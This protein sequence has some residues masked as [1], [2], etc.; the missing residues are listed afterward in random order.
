MK[1]SWITAVVVVSLCTFGYV[2]AQAS[3]SDPGAGVA[4][5]ATWRIDATH[6]EL[7]F[8]IRHL[9][10]RVNGTFGKWG[11]T[12]AADPENLAG[13]SV[14]ISIE[15]ASIDT[16]HERRDTHL[17]SADFFDA[18]QHP[19]ITFKSTGIATT[20]QQI[21]ITGDLTIRGVTRP[22]VLEGTYLGTTRDAQGKQRIGFEAQTTVNRHD[23]Q[24]SWNR[25]VE[26]GTMLLGDE[27]TIQMVVAA[28]EQ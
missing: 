5:P 26:A 11:G 15:T 7:T 14:D 1:R 10:S 27:V 20:G 6:S 13:G 24:V 28:V 23:F 17:R 9:V 3:V 16:N 21:R 18:E 25:T 4:A 19:A 12:L 2:T 8:R 22:V